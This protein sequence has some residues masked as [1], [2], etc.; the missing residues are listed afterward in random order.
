MECYEPYETRKQKQYIIEKGNYLLKA[1]CCDLSSC[2]LL[3]S[4][5]QDTSYKCNDLFRKYH[6]DNLDEK[7]NI[8]TE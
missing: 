8:L 1:S 4:D 3:S 7:G 5:I 2:D 6:E